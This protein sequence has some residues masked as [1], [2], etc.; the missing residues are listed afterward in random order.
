MGPAIAAVKQQVEQTQTLHFWRRSRIFRRTTAQL[1]V[2][3]SAE[4]RYCEA[5]N[6]HGQQPTTRKFHNAFYFFLNRAKHRLKKVY[7]S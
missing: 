3:V 6:N 2:V 1:V 7:S 5:T 4:S